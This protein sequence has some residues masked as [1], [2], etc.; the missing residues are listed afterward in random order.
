M[1]GSR[2]MS[3][4]GGRLLPTIVCFLLAAGGGAMLA[5]GA[6]AAQAC[7]SEAIRLEETFAS[8]LPDC[9][10]YEQ[11][12]P[13]AKNLAD[14][15]G[16]AVNS[17]VAA[18]PSGTAATFYSIVPFPGS[19]GS[20]A[21]PEYLSTRLGTTGEEAW[22]TTDLIPP[23][24]PGWFGSGVLGWTEDLVDT[25]V[26]AEEPPLV[27][28][29]ATPETPNYYIHRN[30][31][32]LYAL[33]ARGP[34]IVYLAGGSADDSRILFE[35]SESLIEGAAK[36]SPNLYEW[37]EGQLILIATD[38]VAG[39]GAQAIEAA[40]PGGAQSGYYTKNTMSQDGSHVF[41]TD[42]GNGQI[43]MRNNKEPPVEVS[44]SQRAVPEAE[45]P[46]HWRAATPD[47]RYVFFTSEARLTEDAT[48]STGQPDLYRYDTAKKDN[49]EPEGE[50]L[51]DLTQFAGEGANVLGTSGISADGSYAYFVA[52]KVL[53]GENAEHRTPIAGASNLYVWHRDKS[54]GKGAISFLTQLNPGNDAFDWT[55]RFN[56]GGAGDDEG[57]TSSRV[58]P[59]GTS[60]L[61]S[62]TEQLTAF[63]NV[64]LRELYLYTAEDESLTCVS[65]NPLASEATASGT[66]P[67]AWLAT[68]P[69]G[70]KPS[71]LTPFLS[72]NLSEDGSRVF[73]AT[74]EALV[75][76]DTN[77]KMDVYEWEREGAGS[78]PHGYGNC[79]YLIS[80]GQSA[81]ESYFGNASSTGD[82]VF[83]FTSQSLVSQD[84]DYN[85]DLY[86]AHVGGGIPAQNPPPPVPCAGE[87]CHGSPSRAPQFEPPSSM[88]FSG[89]E[90]PSTHS[91]K[92]AGIS[93]KPRSL[94]RAQKLAHALRACAKR[95][96]KRRA[97]C[98][99]LAK[100]RYG[101]TAKTRARNGG[102]K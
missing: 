64:G 36:G 78:C 100:R 5:P 62:S 3:R 7:T 71:T 94:T 91:V 87:V 39:P 15:G 75:E 86:D 53:A 66:F 35:D 22:S 67:G 54:S 45:E 97:A 46:A 18:S 73:F 60:L 34:G 89:P 101:K 38:A 61:F 4:H 47:G 69:V 51:L 59:A 74:E 79:I 25:I 84:R 81:S 6:P 32:D 27:S 17:D 80:T 102:G 93:S 98:R 70:V 26:F 28:E 12:S 29:G 44:A 8:S 43:Y 49:G 1:S 63:D 52:T 65:C 41:Y 19:S 96:K 23:S 72:R 37:S 48:A 83:F 20:A 42:V 99:M 11:V 50:A 10:A 56:G 16:S 77:G 82:D 30:G 95:P 88:A 9:R 90:G 40:P 13:I 33:L 68:E 31:T 85:V 92:N 57:A 55:G 21:Y 58:T 2:E 14:A 24:A 76:G